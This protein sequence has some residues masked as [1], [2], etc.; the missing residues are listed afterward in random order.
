[1]KKFL[2]FTAIVPLLALA[3][4]TRSPMF[5]TFLD[6]L[7]NAKSLKVDYV[8]QPIGGAGSELQVRLEKPNKFRI[9]SDER[10]VIGDGSTLTV[11]DRKE[12][13]YFKR[14]QTEADLSAF[15][16]GMDNHFWVGFF[17][18]KAVTP[19]QSRDR[20]TVNR[21]GK[22]FAVVEATYG[23]GENRVVYYLDRELN[24]PRMAEVNETTPAGAQSR[25]MRANELTVNAT[26][27]PDT[28]AFNAPSGSKEVPEAEFEAVKFLNNLEE[29]KRLAKSTGKKIFVDFYADW[30]APCK[31]L[32]AEV[33]PTPEF[34]RLSSKLVFVKIDVDRQTEVAQAYR[35]E[36]MPTQMVLNADGGVESTKVGYANKADFFA[37]LN[38]AVGR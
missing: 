10:I 38:P 34:R 2:L 18:P 15:L 20:G 11:L 24:L 9:V 19:A 7:R 31:K 13:R 8:V 30:C 22:E 6:S 3:A 1:M 17:A 23:K 27:T 35:I 21:A 33:F 16:P 32:A 14:A 4:D 5:A 29:A 36:A 37:W 25:V 12:N 28:F 26:F